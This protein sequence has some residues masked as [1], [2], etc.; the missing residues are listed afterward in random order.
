MQNYHFISYSWVDASEFAERLYD[1][2]LKDKPPIQVWMDKH[3]GQPGEFWNKQVYEAIRACNSLLF[4]MTRS[5][6]EDQSRC[7]QEWYHALKYKKSVIPILLHPDA[8]MPPDL[9]PRLY[10]NFTREFE[11]AFDE[12]RKRLKWL[13]SPE[14]ILQTLQ[15]RL[16]GRQRDLRREIN[17]QQKI[18]IESEIAELKDQIAH[19]SKVVSDPKGA[20]KRVEESIAV[21]IEHE[22]QPRKK[23]SDTTR[24]KFINPT[25]VVAPSYFQN[26]FDETKLIGKFLKDDALRLI[27]VVGRGGIGKTALVCRLLRAL[28]NECLP[29]DGGKLTVDGIVYLSAIGSH[30]VNFPNF[31]TDLCRLLPDEFSDKLDEIYKDPHISIE[32]KMQ[33]LLEAFPHGRTILLLDNFED[34]VDPETRNINDTELSDALKALLNL[35]QHAV[36]V[37]LTTRIAPKNLALMQPGRQTRIDLDQGLESPFAE[38]ILREMDADGKIGLKSASDELLNKAR[39]RTRGYPRAL[40]ALFAILSVDR[41]TTLEEILDDAEKQLPENVVNALIGEAFSRL[42]STAQKVM[43]A[44]AIYGRPVPPFAID[45]ILKPFILGINATPVLN[46]LVNMQFARKEAGRYYLHPLDRD[47]AL[48]RIPRGEASDRDADEN[49][50]PFAQITLFYR[51]AN[52]FREIRTPTETWNSIADLAPQLAEFDLRCAGKEYDSAANVLLK[53]DN[54]LRKWGN[55]VLVADLYE[56]LSGKLQNSETKQ[57]CL[58]NLGWIY[59]AIG[60]LEKTLTY[61]QDALELAQMRNDR[62][63]EGYLFMAL[64][65]CYGRKLQPYLAKDYHKR[66]RVIAKEIKDRNLEGY[67]IH[68]LGE[69]HRDLGEV[70]QAIECYEQAVK[71]ARETKDKGSEGNNLAFLGD[72]LRQLGQTTRAIEYC[73]KALAILREANVR[74]REAVCLGFLGRCIQEKGDTALAM[75][76]FEQAMEIANEL[77]YRLWQPSHM[78]SIGKLYIDQGQLDKALKQFEYVIQF[79]DKYGDDGDKISGRLNLAIAHLFSGNLSEAKI[80]IEDSFKFFDEKQIWYF[81]KAF[82]GVIMMRQG[83]SNIAQKAFEAVILGTEKELS[84]SDEIY[85]AYDFKAI[86]YCGLALCKGGKDYIRKAKEAYQA[87]R[88]ITKDAGTVRRVL[89]LFDALAVAD[90]KGILAEVRPVITGE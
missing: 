49:E 72:Y 44:L 45:F 28:E 15:V 21:G 69:I 8:E 3:Y 54:Y 39:Q 65:Q 10:I 20:A 82:L 37:V 38:N 30:R 40:E 81:L 84:I 56:R 11:P 62:R 31:Y 41:D 22:R 50:L 68:N 57:Y 36:K 64:G 61:F 71:I 2:L 86:S 90:T 32:S 7:H 43:Q 35:P 12:L 60:P 23:I 24:T 78:N 47:Y 83:D 66:G 52:Y 70:S 17:P 51:G 80:G 9:E 5:S 26:R 42:D 75:K 19:Q 89:R 13:D 14:G 77:K 67:C 34:V 73:E 18:R 25:P 55:Y 6:V 53:I 1:T 46:R 48:S 87:A 58:Y 74:S 33:A 76:Y 88:K 27:T 4:V 16:S 85:D 79:A 59:Y 63:V 29:D